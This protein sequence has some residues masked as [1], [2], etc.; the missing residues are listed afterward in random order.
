MTKGI[1]I[2]INLGT[3]TQAV[4]KMRPVKNRKQ[5]ALDEAMPRKIKKPATQ[6]V[7]NVWEMSP[8]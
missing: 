2:N 4:R 7:K 1:V 5:S 8:S 6:F 3:P